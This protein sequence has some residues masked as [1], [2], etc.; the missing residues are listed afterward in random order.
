MLCADNRI[1][2]NCV[3]WYI[4]ASPWWLISPAVCIPHLPALETKWCFRGWQPFASY[5]RMPASSPSPWIHVK[6]LEFDLLKGVVTLASRPMSKFSF[7]CFRKICFLYQFSSVA[8]SCLTLC[9]SLDCSMPASLS[10]TNSWSP[11]NPMSIESV[12]PSNHLILCCPL[13]LWPSI[14]PS[15]RVFSNES[16]LHIRWPKYW[17][18]SFNISPSNE[19][20]GLISFRMDWLDL[21]SVQGT[22]KSLFQHHS[23][24]ASI[25]GCS[26]F[27]I[28]QL[29]HPYVTTGKTIALTR[30]TFVG[31]VTSLLFHM[32]FSIPASRMRVS[33][34]RGPLVWVPHTIPCAVALNCALSGQTAPVTLQLYCSA[35]VSTMM[36][37]RGNDNPLQYSCLENP[38]GR[39]PWQVTVHGVTKSQTP[40]GD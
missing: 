15:I 25:L 23:S 38:M 20:S 28:V 6:V 27:F 17:S 21:L 1:Q 11:P 40:L 19:Y 32:V 8:Q 35:P 39:A 7:S 2:P 9:N 29:S 22:L 13:L 33:S 18:F 14:F 5:A 3:Q 10:I 37:G 16:A 4:D 36:P 31:K 12:I 34:H 26:A 24:K 30:W